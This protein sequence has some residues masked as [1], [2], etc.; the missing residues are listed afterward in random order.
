MEQIANALRAVFVGVYNKAVERLSSKMSKS[1][2]LEET[3]YKERSVPFFK[4]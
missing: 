2:N 4:A 3:P 1:Q